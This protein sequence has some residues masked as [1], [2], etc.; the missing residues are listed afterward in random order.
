MDA[1][2]NPQVPAVPPYSEVVEAGAE[3]VANFANASFTA[4]RTREQQEQL[5]R[6]MGRVAVQGTHQPK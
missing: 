4:I 1:P 2:Q 5:A 6:E 3:V